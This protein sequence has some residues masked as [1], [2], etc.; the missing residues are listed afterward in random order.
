MLGAHWGF[1][2][3][4]AGV[5]GYHLVTLITTVALN[6]QTGELDLLQLPAARCSCWPSCRT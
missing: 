2:A 1:A 6:R 5:A 3:F 4:F